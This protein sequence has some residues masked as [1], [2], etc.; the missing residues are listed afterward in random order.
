MRTP[1]SKE[2]HKRTD[3]AHLAAQDL[4]YPQIFQCPRE[5]MT[6]E[7][8]SF[9]DTERGRVL[10]GE[11]KVDRVVHIQR[12]DFEHEFEFTIQERFRRVQENQPY[13]DITIAEECLN[14][15]TPSELYNCHASFFLYGYYDKASNTF[16]RTVA[17]DV[18]YLRYFL[19]H[20]HLTYT[21]RTH[22]TQNKRFATVSFEDLINNKLIFWASPDVMEG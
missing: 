21:T 7:S 22:K 2:N 4:L 19:M 8:P 16:E 13:R 10:D 14:S 9:T 6:F 1:H 18:F 3:R 12:P 11:L 5:W 20:R 15:G 17:V